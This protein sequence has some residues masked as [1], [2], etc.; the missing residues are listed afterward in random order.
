[1]KTIYMISKDCLTG[2]NPHIRIILDIIITA[3]PVVLFKYE[4]GGDYFDKLSAD[5]CHCW[6]R[7]KNP[8]ELM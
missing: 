7:F 2:M 1:M 8:A 3:G 6:S 4:R 5:I